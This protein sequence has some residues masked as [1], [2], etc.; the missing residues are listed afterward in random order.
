MESDRTSSRLL[1]IVLLS[2]WSSDFALDNNNLLISM[3]KTWD[4]SFDK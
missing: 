4:R 1:L 2:L 3:H